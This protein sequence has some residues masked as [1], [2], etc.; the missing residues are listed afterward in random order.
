MSEHVHFYERIGS[1]QDEARRLAEAGAPEGTLVIAEEQSVGRGRMARTWT[2]PP[3][4]SLLMSVVYRPRTIGPGEAYRLVMATGLAYAEGIEG[5]APEAGGA[6]IRI[7][8]KWPNDL[9]IAGRKVAGILPESAIE[10]ERLK[11]VIVG[12]G[13]NV[14]QQFEA[15]DPLAGTAIS[16]KMATGRD[17]DRQD[18]LARIVRGLGR[19]NARLGDGRRLGAAW[20]A[21]CVTLGQRVA[22]EAGGQRVAGVA[23][24]LDDGGVLWVR[25]D[26]GERVRLTAG[27]ASVRAEP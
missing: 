25:T 20:R 13:L 16:L 21:R 11:W 1:T 22:A 3:G 5:G 26:G 18:L 7:D 14:N 8:V 4:T 27:E 15:E 24:E 10:G 12:V 6:G 17:L 23:E 9:Q 19:W 2:A